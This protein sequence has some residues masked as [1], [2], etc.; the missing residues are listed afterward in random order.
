MSKKATRGARIKR[1]FVQSEYI[2]AGW[3]WFMT[4][5]GRAAEPILVISVLYA[6]IKLLPVVRFP[7]QLD[8]VVFIAQFVALDVG[9]LSL[10]KLADQAAK[11]GNPD[12]A[13][14]A[15]RLSIALVIIMLVGVIMAGI[16][17][18]VTLDGQAGTVI[19]TILV[20]ARAVM[21]VLYSRVIHSLKRDDEP[22][23]PSQEEI[24][25]R[26]TET[27]N[28]AL[29]HLRQELVTEFET[30]LAQSLDE[31]DSKLAERVTA[32]VETAM[33]KRTTTPSRERPPVPASSKVRS[34][35]D[36]PS[37]KQD[38]DKV[39]WPL[40]N[41]GLSVRAI[42]TKANTS[43]ATVGRSRQRWLKANKQDDET[44]EAL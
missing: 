3:N 9:G 32:A 17:Q 20:I 35:A 21:A 7:P 43:T 13:K 36:A 12:G 23:S 33:Q 16:D 10:N 14:Q 27:V 29:K 4:L 30:K 8:V 22:E 37:R 44:V 19:D 24:E 6:S 41:S 38:I 34:I 42:A 11:D 2:T 5:A 25:E 18:I 15:R 39:I 26:V 1:S 31:R 40:L 28:E